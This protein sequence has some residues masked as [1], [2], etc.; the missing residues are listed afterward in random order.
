MNIIA[1]CVA[2]ISNFILGGI[3]YSLLF[4]KLWQKEVGLSN[5]QLKASGSLPFI[6]SF[7]YSLLAA[8]GFNYL[9]QFSP[10]LEH[11]VIVGLIVGILLVATSM[12]TNYQFAGRSSKLFLIDAGYHVA[13]FILYAFIFWYL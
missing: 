5:E 3:W 7:F 13:Q 12:G 2:T 6:L 11:N 9:V 10:S 8:L 4:G 1:I